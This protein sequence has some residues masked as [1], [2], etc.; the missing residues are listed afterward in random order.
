M[1]LYTI[2]DGRIVCYS[3]PWI[4]LFPLHLFSFAANICTE[5]IIEVV[6][7]H[8]GWSLLK[9]SESLCSLVQEL[10]SQWQFKVPEYD[11][12]YMSELRLSV[13]TNG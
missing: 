2:N 3:E 11:Y 12:H 4:L 1:S 10:C 5:K 9:T 6:T 7:V 8:V 13:T